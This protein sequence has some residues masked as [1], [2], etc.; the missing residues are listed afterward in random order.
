[1][2]SLINIGIYLTYILIAVAVAGAILF[3]IVQ[4]FGNLKKA[5]GGLIGVGIILI[6]FLISYAVSPAESGAFYDKFAISPTGS[7]V[8]GA[9][10]VST[11]IMAVGVLLSI[12]YSET[13]KWL[14]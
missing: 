2:D 9:G 3:P 7:K 1:M 10:L 4:T 5:K 12:L 11:Y 14:K 8:I 6:I 13:T